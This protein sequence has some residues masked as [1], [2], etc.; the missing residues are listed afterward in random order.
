MRIDKFLSNL[1]YG[2]RS[3]IKQFLK[4]HEVKVDDLRV[5]I[6]SFEVDPNQEKVFI[7]HE[8]VFYKYPIYLKIHKPK[9][10]LSA[11]HDSMHPCV[12]DLLK[13]PYDRFDFA[14][15]GRLDLD[16][17]GLMI[18][19][20]DGAFAHQITMPK[21]HVP[22]IYEVELEEPFEADETLLKGVIIKDG[23][24]QEYLAKALTIE[25][26]GKI[27]RITIDEGKFHQVKRMF[28]TTGHLV[29]KLKRIQIGNLK[30]GDLP[31]GCYEPF[32]KEEIYD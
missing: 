3:E 31:V 6:P 9:G 8:S 14:I 29:L 32:E 12:T 5:F 21:S 4:D 11:N 22:K 26:E 10:Y 18:L 2:S 23:K 16:A 13:E 30:L 17:E 20:T 28:Q 7:D 24:N 1:K 19:S 25:S 15:A 27:V